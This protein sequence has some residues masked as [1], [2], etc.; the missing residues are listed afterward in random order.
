[1]SA[2]KSFCKDV[3]A[4]AS[5]SKAEEMALDVAFLPTESALHLS[6]LMPYVAAALSVAA[7]TSRFQRSVPSASAQYASSCHRVV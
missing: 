6:E 2:H 5:P 4:A 1:M 3:T 7:C